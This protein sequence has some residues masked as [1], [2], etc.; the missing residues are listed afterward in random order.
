VAALAATAAGSASAQGQGQ[1]TVAVRG[2][3]AS[4]DKS[5][6]LDA[7]P[8]MGLDAMYGINNWLSIGP[9]LSLGRPQTTGS[10]FVSVITYGVL[11]LGDT[12]YFFEATQPVNVLDGA[13]NVRV[14]LPGRKLSPYATAGIGGYTLF[15]DVQ[16]NRGER[17][18]AGLSFNAGAGALYALTERA[19]ITFDIRSMTYTDYDRKVLDPRDDVVNFRTRVEETLYA[20]DFKASPKSKSTVTNFVFSFGFSYVPFFFGGGGS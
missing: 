10:H 8:M 4:F 7:T 15:L 1:V 18:K 16:A 13:L 9:A 17:H 3:Y 11:S 12:T 14:Q 19:G 6:S 5:A 2:G 20:E